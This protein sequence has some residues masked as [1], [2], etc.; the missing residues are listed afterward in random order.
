MEIGLLTRLDVRVVLFVA[1]TAIAAAT[2]PA[3]AQV[4]LSCPY[5]G[6]NP[7][8]RRSPLDSVSFQIGGQDVKLCYGRPSARGRTMIGGRAAPF[9]RV[10]RT[11][12]NETTKIRTTTRLSIAGIV[13]DP[14]TYAIY[15]IPGESEW[16]VIVNRA[17]HQ[18]GRENY[19]TEAVRA[20]E[21]ARARVPVEQLSEH[22]ET[23]TI[24]AV[25]DTGGVQLVFEWEHTRVR[26]PVS[27]AGRGS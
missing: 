14:G 1:T 12:A 19:Y 13:V 8:D 2:A 6:A 17:W 26:V 24:R 9:G 4:D 20:Q 5:R 7:A 11:G 18:W 21:I 25:P 22:I 23:F 10:W 27:G 16:Q 3:A 15:T